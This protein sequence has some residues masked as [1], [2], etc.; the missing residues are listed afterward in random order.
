VLPL[1]CCNRGTHC[2]SS[3]QPCP[4]LR[5]GYPWPKPW[6]SRADPT[7]RPTLCLPHSCPRAYVGPLAR[8]AR[9]ACFA[10]SNHRIPPP[11][12]TNRNSQHSIKRLTA[13][14][15]GGVQIE[16]IQGCVCIE[17]SVQIFHRRGDGGRPCDGMRSSHLVHEILNTAVLP[18]P[19]AVPRHGSATFRVSKNGKLQPIISLKKI[20]IP[21]NWQIFGQHK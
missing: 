6:F 10:L 21:E 20:Y 14:P 8:P 19:S 18:T 2:F 9:Q 15:A 1:G 7:G 17:R 4:A 3:R 11:G 13:N 12:S 5:P 16:P